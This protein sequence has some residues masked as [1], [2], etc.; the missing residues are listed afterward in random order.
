LR[1]AKERDDAGCLLAGSFYGCPLTQ[2]ILPK[3]FLQESVINTEQGKRSPAA[4]FIIIAEYNPQLHGFAR[5]IFSVAKGK[6]GFI[7]QNSYAKKRF[8]DAYPKPS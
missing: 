8:S 3:C 6:W 4:E 5:A 7:K 2:V 1:L